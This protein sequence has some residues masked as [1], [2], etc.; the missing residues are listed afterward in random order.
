LVKFP[1]V[2][3]KSATRLAFY[4]LRSSSDYARSLSSA[5]LE[6]KEKIRLCSSCQSL[7][8][9]DPC[10]ICSD[11]KRDGETICVVEEP[12]DLLAIEKTGAFKGLY[13]VLHG[14]LSPLDGVGSEDLKIG[15]LIKRLGGDT[16][17][18]IIVATNPNVEGEA[19]AL[20]LAKMVK[21]L[22]IKLTR[23][24]SGVP[25]GSDLEYIDQY[26]LSRAI[27]ARREF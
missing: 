5:I 20:Y 13:H 3:E 25:V 15:D 2:G 8:E 11:P 27:E 12:S 9:V 26:T 23:I 10:S 24:A 19:T 22:G 6:V 7:T 18:E 14:V 17:S 16:V 21:P 4:I 1:G